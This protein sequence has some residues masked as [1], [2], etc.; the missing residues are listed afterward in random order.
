VALIDPD[1]PELEAARLQNRRAREWH[2]VLRHRDDAEVRVGF[3]YE[4]FEFADAAQMA[5]VHGAWR[6]YRFHPW[7][8]AQYWDK[9]GESTPRLGTGVGVRPWPKWSVAGEIWTAA[10]SNVL[11]ELEFR[12]GVGRSLPWGFGVGVDYRHMRFDASRVDVA[13][14]TVE[15]YFPF[16]V[17][18]SF[19]YHRA[20]TTFDSVE[21]DAPHGASRGRCDP[22]A[23]DFGSCDGE[24]ANDSFSVRYHQQLTRRLRLHLGYASG[25]QSF[26]ALAID[27]V[28]RFDAQT[29]SLGVDVELGERLTLALGGAREMRDRGGDVTAVQV[30]LSRFF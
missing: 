25:T 10:G 4:D 16:P 19:N 20:W 2:P 3:Q 15:Y 13:T 22:S 5:F 6:G 17:W 24:T 14:G 21:A 26:Q 9:F 12:L 28:G 30:A 27:G 11:A 18:M 8:E 1:H 7:V 29:V 23:L